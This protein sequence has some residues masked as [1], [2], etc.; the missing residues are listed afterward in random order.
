MVHKR[1]KGKSERI[2]FFTISIDPKLD[3]S[4]AFDK[5]IEYLECNKIP[6]KIKSRGNTVIVI[7]KE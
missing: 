7:S 6:Y 5:H 3:E 1:K 4:Y 2:E